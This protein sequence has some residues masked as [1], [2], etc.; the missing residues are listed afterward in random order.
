MGLYQTQSLFMIICDFIID[1]ARCSS[2]EDV[3]VNTIN[4]DEF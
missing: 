1:M 3:D 4:I 2:S